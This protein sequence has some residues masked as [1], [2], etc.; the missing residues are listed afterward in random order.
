MSKKHLPGPIALL[1]EAWHIYTNRFGTLLSIMFSGLL[2]IFIT[3]FIMALGSIGILT[4]THATGILMAIPFVIAGVI[5]VLLLS[6]VSA[7]MQLGM[8]HAVA[9]Y[10]EKVGVRES[11]IRA[12][13]DIASYWWIQLLMMLIVVTG[14][15]CFFIP[16]LV[17]LVWFTFAAYILIA[18]K[19]KGM[20]AIVKSREYVR[21]RFWPV[22]G[23]MLFLAI[24]YIIL[25]LLRINTAHDRESTLFLSS[26]LPN[27]VNV[28]LTPLQVAYGFVLYNKLK[29]SH[30]E[31]NPR[32][33]QK[34]KRVFSILAWIGLV[35]LFA[36]TILLGISGAFILQNMQPKSSAFYGTRPQNDIRR[37]RDVQRY[38]QIVQIQGVL[39]VYKQTYNEYPTT[40]DQL[41][42]NQLIDKNILS[43]IISKKR[44]E[45]LPRKDKKDYK[46]CLQPELNIRQC[47][48]SN[49]SPDLS[50]IDDVYEK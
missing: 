37:T 16:G 47:F 29:S 7:L 38:S 41:V 15:L 49:N 11:Y 32:L 19:T 1:K 28:L 44:F 12:W 8:M 33:L 50:G 36:T 21:G 34:Q 39:E 13:K 48:S 6:V 35:I 23:R 20:Q 5:F 30:V 2:V 25:S 22:V 9:G 17:F 45:Y 26:A 43:D 14:I 27:I 40:L 4:I 24:P 3:V 42:I 10:K 31:S 18:E 46:L